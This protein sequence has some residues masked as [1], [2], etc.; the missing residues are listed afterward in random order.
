MSTRAGPSPLP[1][2]GSRLPQ[3]FLLRQR[4]AGLLTPGAEK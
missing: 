2:V 4:E 1:E 3:R